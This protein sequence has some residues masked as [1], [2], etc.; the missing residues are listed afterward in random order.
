M[1]KRSLLRASGVT[2]LKSVAEMVRTPRP[3]ICSKKLRLRTLRMKKTTF[4]RLDVGAG[5][6]HVHRHDYAGVVAV[7]EG[8]QQVFRPGPGGPVGDLLAEV[9]ALV[10]LLAHDAHDVIGVAVV[11]GEDDG[12]GHIAAAGE[13]VREQALPKGLDDCANLVFRHHVAVKPVGGVGQVLVQPLPADPPGQPVPP[14]DVVAGLHR[15]PLLGDL[16]ANPVGVEV[17]VYL[18]DH[19]LLVGVLHDQVLLEEAEGLL[20][21]RCGQSDQEAVEVLKHLP[22]EVVDGAVTLVG[23]DDVEGLDGDVGVVLDGRG[24]ALEGARVKAGKLLQLRGQ[25]FALQG[26]VDPLDG[27]DADAAHGVDAPGLKELDVVQLGELAPL[28]RVVKPWNSRR[29]WR[30]RLLRS[31]RNSTRRAPACLI[32]R[33]TWL[34]AMKVLPLP[35]AICT[36]ARGRRR[37]ETPPGS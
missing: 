21:G 23:D 3:F 7:A 25:L 2:A 18:V 1:T 24:L 17:D 12:L 31:T 5:G 34:Q 4:H 16:G 30:P 26:G 9:V 32:R 28:V 22:P 29:V 20:G 10:E 36:S 27:G 35:V 19:G 33:Y 11:L 37:P 13:Y 8:G 14:V 6:D 15:G